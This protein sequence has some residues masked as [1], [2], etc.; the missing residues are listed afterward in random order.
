MEPTPE[1]RD[2]IEQL[3]RYGG[4]ELADELERMGRAARDLVPELVGLS[5]GLV[6]DGLTF[7]LVASDG[8]VASLDAV[9]YVGGGPCV[10]AAE[11]GESAESHAD[12]LFSERRWLE[13]AQAQ[14]AYGVASTLSLPVL[15]DG[16]VIG[17]INLY[18]ATSEAFSGR[19]NA[20]AAA[21]GASANDAIANADL[22]F[23]TRM[24]AAATTGRLRDLDSIN[25]AVGY[26]ASVH[27]VGIPAA[28]ALLGGAAARA[29]ITEGQAAQVLLTL[30]L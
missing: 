12:D 10:E 4:H 1:T 24:E 28:R 7:T 8:E 15:T 27:G 2:S 18:A 5:L 21:L 11:T 6:Q 14:A 20:L 19:R 3:R 23:T 30:R 16:E 25:Q 22:S 9:Q 29:G 26:I 13:F 17:G